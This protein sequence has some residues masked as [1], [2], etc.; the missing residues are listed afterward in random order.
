VGA[1]TPVKVIIGGND[2]NAEPDTG[3]DVLAFTVERDINQPDMAAVVL[4]NQEA[5]WS[6]KV[7]V[8]DKVEIKVG[9]DAGTS[10]YQGEVVGLEAAYKGGERARLTVRCMNN[11]HKLLRQRKSITFT[12]KTDQAILSQVVKDAGL[13]LQWKHEKSITYKHVYQHNQTNMEFLRM[14]AGRLGCHIWCV[15]DQL[16]VQEPD[17]NAGPVATLRL[18]AQ[19]DSAIR[20]FRP[21]MNSSS[22][23]KKVTVKGWNPETK[24]LVQGDYAAQSS[25]LG[26]QNASSHAAAQGSEE[27]F[28]VDHP[29]W[30]VDEAKALAKAR[31]VDQSLGYI[32]G[33]VEIVGDPKFDL[34]KIVKIVA[35]QESASGEDPFN[36]SY[37]IMG[38]THKYLFTKTKEGGYVTT[39]RLARDAAKE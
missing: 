22:V 9:D 33:E 26:S 38:I 36:G 12:D 16:F 17:L 29:I 19:G 18:G 28:T 34:G 13:S 3:G 23:L 31:L 30:S 27:S 10:I 7:K 6:T 24:E 11:M 14:R 5:L 4:S 20:E 25:K 8:S 37:Y 35:S 1:A 15:G 39:L 21:R 32:T 2:V